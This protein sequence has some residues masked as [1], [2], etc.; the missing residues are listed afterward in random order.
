MNTVTHNDNKTA[1]KATGT[2]ICYNLY[3]TY[4]MYALFHSLSHVKP[5]TSVVNYYLFSWKQQIPRD[6]DRKI[7]LFSIVE[8]EHGSL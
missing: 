1:K 4:I 8:R 6:T 7:F 2:Y 5:C 3:R